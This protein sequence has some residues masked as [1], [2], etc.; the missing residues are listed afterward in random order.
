[1]ENFISIEKPKI[2]EIDSQNGKWERKLGCPDYRRL[3]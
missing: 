3:T 1:M 2:N